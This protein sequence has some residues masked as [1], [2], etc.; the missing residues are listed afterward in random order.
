[1]LG[2]GVRVMIIPILQGG[3]GNQIFQIAAA[4]SLAKDNNDEVAINYNIEHIGLQKSQLYYRDNIYKKIKSTDIIPTGKYTEPCFSYKKIP[5]VNNMC[6]HG[7]FQSEKYF[8]KYKDEINNLFEFPKDVKDKVDTFLEKYNGI[9]KIGIHYRR[10]DYVKYKNIYSYLGKEYYDAAKNLIRSKKKLV[11]LNC[12]DDFNTVLNEFNIDGEIIKLGELEDLYLL[13]QCNSIITSNS[14]YVWWA[15][16]L[17]KKKDVIVMPEKWFGIDGVKDYQ[18][19]Y[20]KGCIK[21]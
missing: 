20:I 16:W 13:S 1:M 11:Y 5:Y 3:L 21:I 12:S 17:G 7:Y 15:A 8:N 2:K 4:Y 14:S 19:I 10:G 6:I 18:D 9:Y